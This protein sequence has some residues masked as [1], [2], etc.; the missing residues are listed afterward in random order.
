MIR[1]IAPWDPE[2]ELFEQFTL[3]R[4]LKRTEEDG[5]C[6]RWT[7]HANL[8]RFP[9]VRLGGEAGRAYSVR[10]VLWVLTRGFLVHDWG[11]SVQCN[12]HE[13]CVH[14]DH[15]LV[16][17]PSAAQQGKPKPLLTVRRMAI[18]QRKRSRITEEMVQEIRT[19]TAPG[20]EFDRRWNL[21]DGTAAHI[22]A[23][24]ARRDLGIDILAGRR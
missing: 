21:G 11:V 17:P 16:R 3:E 24:R 12:C 2:L 23:G 4:L 15:L 9:Q 19:S 14:P 8:G 18:A 10:R 13:L 7:G 5:D 6:L 22:R 1:T 20:V